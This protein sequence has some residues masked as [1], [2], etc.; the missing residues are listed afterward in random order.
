M[1]KQS[2]KVCAHLQ[3]LDEQHKYHESQRRD[4]TITSV[5]ASGARVRH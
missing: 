1:T 3:L 5:E 2:R 4:G